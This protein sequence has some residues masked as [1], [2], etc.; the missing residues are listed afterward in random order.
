MEFEIG[1]TYHIK[2]PNNPATIYALYEAVIKIFPPPVDA[3]LPPG[4]CA[5]GNILAI[6][7][8]E[9]FRSA[10]IGFLGWTWLTKERKEVKEISIE[11]LPLYVSWNVSEEFTGLLSEQS[12]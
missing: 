4:C 2:W 3:C 11:D 9:S 7:S 5:Y 6:R 12:K 8:S 10:P 1:K